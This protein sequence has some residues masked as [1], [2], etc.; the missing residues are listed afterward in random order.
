MSKPETELGSAV[1]RLVAAGLLFRQG[2]RPH[3]TYLFKHALVQDAAYGTLLREPRRALH[4]RIAET[5]E[6]RFGEIADSQP[7]LLA[8]HFTEAGLIEKAAGW[9]GKAGRRSLERSALDEALAQLS[10]ALN[11][12]ITL[13]ETSSLRR[14]R[15][16]LQIAQTRALGLVKGMPH[17]KRRPRQSAPVCWSTKLQRSESLRRHRSRSFLAPG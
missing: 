4:A 1:D 17:P 2:V 6:I 16:N 10:R 12:I 5:V 13:P 15:I 14:E 3:A 11:Q 8:R 7:E 9:W